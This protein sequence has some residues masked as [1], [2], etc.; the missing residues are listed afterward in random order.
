ML[1]LAIDAPF[2][3]KRA[4]SLDWVACARVLYGSAVVMTGLV[5]FSP[6]YRARQEVVQRGR[7]TSRPTTDELL[8]VKF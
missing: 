4:D 3:C 6:I 2:F 7:P 8:D 1:L 5:I